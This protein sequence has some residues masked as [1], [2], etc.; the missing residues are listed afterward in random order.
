MKTIVDFEIERK[1]IIL[2]EQLLKNIHNINVSVSDYTV[3]PHPTVL[4]DI[5]ST[6][7][8]LDETRSKNIRMFLTAND[9]LTFAQLIIEQSNAA[10]S[11]AYINTVR[12]Y[13]LLELEKM[14]IEGKIKKLK[15]TFIQNV[16]KY[17]KIFLVEPISVNNN[18]HTP[19]PFKIEICCSSLTELNEELK[20]LGFISVDIELIGL[21]KS[22]L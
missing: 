21:D 6:E 4:V 16:N 7:T 1:E 9:A 3:S 14:I 12:M 8:F 17:C 22:N 2:T 5:A 10:I 13:K 15:L 20:K 18:Y 19:K 11:A